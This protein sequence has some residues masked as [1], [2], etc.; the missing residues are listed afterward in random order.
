MGFKALKDNQE[1]LSFQIDTLQWSNLKKDKQF[2][3]DL[4]MPCCK[5]KAI[6]KNSSLGLQY[7]AH[8]KKGECI[9]AGESIIHMILKKEL[10][11]ILLNNNYKVEIEKQLLFD[12]YTVR[13]DV[14][15]QIDDINI[16]FEI[17]V[18]SQNMEQM[19]YRSK[20]YSD[21][22]IYVIWLNLFNNRT[23]TYDYFNYENPFIRIYNIEKSSL[24]K[25]YKFSIDNLDLLEF[26]LE[27][28][29]LSITKN[30]DI[31]SK[32]EL[33]FY[34]KDDFY[35]YINRH[36]IINGHIMNVHKNWG[37]YS[38]TIERKEEGYIQRIKGNYLKGFILINFSFE[39]YIEKNP[40]E[41]VI[42]DRD[43]ISSIEKFKSKIKK[44]ALDEGWEVTIG[45][46][47]T[48]EIQSHIYVTKDCV[49]LFIMIDDINN[50]EDIYKY[51]KHE[52]MEYIILSNELGYVSSFNPFYQIYRCSD[53][54]NL[55]DG[56]KTKKLIFSNW[57]ITNLRL[58][59]EDYPMNLIADISI[60][61]YVSVDNH[62]HIIMAREKIKA[63]KNPKLYVENIEGY[64]VIF[65]SK[66]KELI[67]KGE[68]LHGFKRYELNEVLI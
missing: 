50:Y 15:L 34:N 43:E 37:G 24:N 5:T 29:K 52:G 14:F 27:K 62:T 3:S 31:E 59:L 17:Q 48:K 67:I 57:F 25:T 1:Y 21:N 38:N 35:Y 66:Y 33:F 8:H 65:K 12:D 63:T 4:Y 40:N 42:Y 19:L 55:I 6:M 56:M 45:K 44:I 30:I 20:K 46:I 41:L 18:T 47:H 7:F 51:C 36:N 64:P 2:K 32:K 68:Y 22:N 23:Y 10:Y 11:E 54:F 58:T 9:H 28:L 53:S 49:K 16:A 60:D 61:D 13:A 39:Y 26:I